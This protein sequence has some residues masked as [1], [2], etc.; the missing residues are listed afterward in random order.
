MKEFNIEDA[1]RE[2]GFK[3]AEYDG[4]L[5]AFGVSLPGYGEITM[6]LHRNFYRKTDSEM[7]VLGHKDPHL[8]ELYLGDE[9]RTYEDFMTLMRLLFPDSAISEKAGKFIACDIYKRFD[10]IEKYLNYNGRAYVP[11]IYKHENPFDSRSV[12]VMYAKENTQSFSRL[13]VLYAVKA[14]TLERAIAKFIA[15][16]DE[17][18]V[19]KIIRGREW[20]GQAPHAVDFWND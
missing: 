13:K 12:W 10:D 6:Q 8:D 17:L 20:Y 7:C 9:P 15:K 2:I 16:Y 18:C 5:Q 11:L 19:E 1:L 3:V 4:V 14:G